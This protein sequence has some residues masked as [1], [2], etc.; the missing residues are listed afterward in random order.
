MELF[1]KDSLK[2]IINKDSV[3]KNGKMGR[4]T[5]GLGKII[6]LTVKVNVCMLMEIFMKDSGKKICQMGLEFKYFQ[7]EI[8]MKEIGLVINIMGMVR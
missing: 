4:N 5:K 8:N 3:F 6:W 1:I 2:I 7:M